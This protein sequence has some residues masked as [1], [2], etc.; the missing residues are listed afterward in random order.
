VT[1]LLG[2]VAGLALVRLLAP[3]LAA[4][5]FERRNYRDHALPTAGGIVIVVAPVAV[6][7]VLS[8]F[9]PE[10]AEQLAVVAAVGFG[11][12][13]LL[14][15]LAGSGADGR[16]FAGH[17]RALRHGRLT[18]GALKLLGGGA[19]AV[20]LVA[21]ESWGRTLVDAALVALA[22]NLANLFDRAPGRTTKVGLLAFAALALATGWPRELGGVALVVGAAAATLP[23][24]L[25][26]RFM[27]GDTG[28]NA[29]GAALGVGVVLTAEPE[30]R[31]AV[32]AVLLL[33]NLASEL[34]SF[35]RVIDAVPPIRWVDRLGRYGGSP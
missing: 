20:V 30:V 17:L 6:L 28:A 16:G 24:D 29:L 13:G 25:G 34:V 11:F 19:L 14:D 22:A 33:L 31:V 3:T 18:T 8:L 4:P 23:A 32:A 26:E 5:V 15:D 7:A 35:S 21:Q 2:F 12:L 1:L 27:L 9:D 10:R